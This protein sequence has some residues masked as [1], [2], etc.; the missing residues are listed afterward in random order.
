MQHS[1]AEVFNGPGRGWYGTGGC[2]FVTK[3]VPRT[4]IWRAPI[5]TF[6]SEAT[7]IDGRQIAFGFKRFT[8]PLGKFSGAA[9][10]LLL[11]LQFGYEL[12]GINQR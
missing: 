11:R 8:R 3:G 7:V 2:G 4:H 9:A 12:L 5:L 6:L 10:G 1:N